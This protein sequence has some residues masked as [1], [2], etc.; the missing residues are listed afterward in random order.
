LRF[1]QSLTLLYSTLLF[2]FSFSGWMNIWALTGLVLF[3]GVVFS[4]NR[5]A[6]QTVVYELVGRE[7]LMSAL[8]LNA[9]AFQSSK[10]IGPAIGGTTLVWFG[11]AGTFA[12]AMALVVMFTISLSIV[13]LAPTTRKPRERVSIGADMLEGVTYIV[14]HPAVRSQLILLIV[15]A[16]CAKPLSELQPGFAAA[17]FGKDA[18]GLAWL[19]GCHGVGASAAGIWLTF[20]VRDKDLVVLTCSSIIAMGVAIMLFASVHI[21]VLA[22]ILLTFV[23][24]SFV[25]MDISSQTLVQSTI[26]SRF[27]GRTMSIYGMVSQ[28]VPSLG[29]LAMG[30]TA[31]IVGL[32]WPVFVGGAIALV[33]G[34]NA[35]IF[36]DRLH[37]VP[38]DL[39]QAA[40]ATLAPADPGAVAQD[41]EKSQRQTPPD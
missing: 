11:T 10:F 18:S 6:R 27:R 37:A 14:Q 26:R 9:V 12:I 19:L 22:C 32:P 17:V 40:D 20:G 29:A 5:P 24:F 16:L 34:I 7:Q 8:S 33:V 36:R 35:W 23:G 31:E 25:L 13:K 21:F 15:V 41:Q 1:T 38:D 28:G 39:G 2:V 4:F 30:A 3:R